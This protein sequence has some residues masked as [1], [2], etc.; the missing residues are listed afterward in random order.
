[1]LLVEVSVTC[2]TQLDAGAG[3]DDIGVLDSSSFTGDFTIH[4]GRG[5]DSVVLS[6]DTF[7]G[8]VRI[9]GGIG[10]DTIGLAD[11]YF[12]QTVAING[13]PGNDT[14]LETQT[15]PNGFE[16]GTPILTSVETTSDVSATDFVA[17]FPWV[18]SLLGI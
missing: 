9:Y 14:F 1:M 6:T 13:G 17:A 3:N 11:S 15:F 5:N 16:D 18:S 7:L 10:T 12:Q 8:N 2:N 4:A